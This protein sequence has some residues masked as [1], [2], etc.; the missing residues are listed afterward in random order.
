MCNVQRAKI[1]SDF[2]LLDAV[3]HIN[4]EDNV[5]PRIL[6]D[7]PFK[8]YWKGSHHEVPWLLYVPSND[9]ERVCRN[10]YGIDCRFAACARKS[11]TTDSRALCQPDIGNGTEAAV[12]T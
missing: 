6:A 12:D 2:G 3:E 1:S 11:L 4:Y 5:A 7:M 10:E 9:L 8:K